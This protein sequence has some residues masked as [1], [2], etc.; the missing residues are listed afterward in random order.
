MEPFSSAHSSC[1]CDVNQNS[2]RN[3][4]C[5]T[6]LQHQKI[7]FVWEKSLFM[8]LRAQLLQMRPKN[9]HSLYDVNQSYNISSKYSVGGGK[10]WSKVVFSM[11]LP[12]P[13]WLIR[14]S[15]NFKSRTLS[16]LRFS[17]QF[18]YHAS[19]RKSVPN[20]QSW[21]QISN[22]VWRLFT[23]LDRVQ[24]THNEPLITNLLDIKRNNSLLKML[25]QQSVKTYS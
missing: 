5:L 22:L 18:K 17:R 11:R 16:C 15:W 8:L 14:F 23:K 1:M 20:L 7:Y 13:N 4:T 2:Q 24:P 3:T 19:K 12:V 10:K 21:N 9:A 6:Q 25:L